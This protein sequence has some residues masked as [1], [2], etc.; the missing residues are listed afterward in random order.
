MSN[1]VPILDDIQLILGPLAFEAADPAVVYPEVAEKLQQLREL[2]VEEA[3]LDLI[4]D[5]TQVLLL[6][7]P[8][9]QSAAVAHVMAEIE[10]W[11]KENPMWFGH[12]G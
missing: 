2:K 7:K 10:H 8:G 3:F 1:P 11:K 6:M 5:S 12:L 4:D 9:D